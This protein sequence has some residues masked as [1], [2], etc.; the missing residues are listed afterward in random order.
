MSDAGSPL[1]LRD[2]MRKMR[3]RVAS[4]IRRG[5][6]SK[7][8]SRAGSED[9]DKHS[10]QS[11]HED[12][13][14]EHGELE[15]EHESEHTPSHTNPNSAASSTHSL[16]KSA[17]SRP[18]SPS[19]QTA[20]G[21]FSPASSE[22]VHR[23][24]SLGL[25][26]PGK[27]NKSKGES[28]PSS[29]DVRA[30][31]FSSPGISPVEQE[32]SKLSIPFISRPRTLSHPLAASPILPSSPD[33]EP[34]NTRLKPSHG[35][36][37]SSPGTGAFGALASA[38]TTLA[39]MTA[40]HPGAMSRPKSPSPPSVV[41][42]PPEGTPA[43]AP[44]QIVGPPPILPSPSEQPNSAADVTITPDVSVSTATIPKVE[45]AGH[46]RDKVTTD[47]GDEHEQSIATPLIE[48][49]Q[50]RESSVQG[51]EPLPREHA[52]KRAASTVGSE[53]GWS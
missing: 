45:E 3:K 31:T 28:A 26:F 53:M 35:R 16:N 43:S 30:R 13:D 6:S 5:S 24:R 11:H 41:L 32:P 50:P 20:S 12:S 34:D 25:T 14:H 48:R 36:A 46:P 10:N 15:H 7:N 42:T 19:P 33:K 40:T 23:K 37:A 4:V 38:A 18:A 21:S 27:K 51:R 29:P 22:K 47:A 52:V 44:A 1:Q 49:D 9:A 39:A 17:G 8:K 2:S